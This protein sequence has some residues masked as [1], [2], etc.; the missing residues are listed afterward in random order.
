M[1]S[2]VAGR[3]DDTERIA[4]AGDLLSAVERAIRERDLDALHHA[5]AAPIETVQLV[6]RRAVEAQ[7]LAHFAQQLVGVNV[8][9]LDVQA[10]ETVK[11]QVS[12]GDLSQASRQPVVVGVDMC[13]H[14]MPHVGQPNIQ[15]AQVAF[16]RAQR[17]RRIPAAVDEQ[18]AVV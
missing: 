9:R 5:H 8:A 16:Q 15:S 14:Q 10:L 7:P 13:D 1:A 4:P 6:G 18:V 3:P 11:A 2:R 17:V 12:T